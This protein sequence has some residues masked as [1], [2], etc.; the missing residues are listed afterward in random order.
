MTGSRRLML[1]EAMSILARSTRLPFG[2]SP[3]RMRSNRSRFSATGRSRQGLFLPGSVR[4]P[5][6]LA[7]LVRGEVVDVGLA[8]LDQQDRPL[9]ELLEVVGGVVEV[10]APVEAE[11]AHVLLDGVDV[12]LLFLGGVRVV[13]AQVAAAAELL[14]DPEVQADR[15]GV[16]E[17]EVA[18]GLGREAGDRPSRGVRSSGRRRRSRG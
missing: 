5:A 1:P 11:P 4:V 10:L 13:E 16:A 6:V 8:R 3:L 18:V 9:V 17:V 15:L 2:N 14:G 7:D 12:L